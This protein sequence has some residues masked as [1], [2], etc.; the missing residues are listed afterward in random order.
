[1]SSSHFQAASE[2]ATSKEDKKHA[3]SITKMDVR[4]N[5]S[6]RVRSRW[7]Q[8]VERVRLAAEKRLPSQIYQERWR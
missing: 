3:T 5:G 8:V 7:N 6:F 1:M 2:E 4:R